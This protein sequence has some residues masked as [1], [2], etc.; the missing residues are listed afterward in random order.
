M[1]RIIRLHD[2]TCRALQD[3]LPWYATGRLDPAEHAR[4]EAHVAG[5]PDCQAELQVER[6]LAAE[7]AQLP[8]GV[9]QGWRRMQARLRAEPAAPPRAKAAA[10]LF[11]WAGWATAAATVI[12]VAGVL[13]LSQGRSGRYHALGAPSAARPGNV[14]V[15]FRPSTREMDL[16]RALK[17]ADARLVD[18]P[19]DADAYVLAVRP[20]RRTAALRQLRAEADVVL[21]EPV[22]PGGG[23]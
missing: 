1:G 3:L 14:V 10:A 23:P 15:I 16:R 8:L 20:E 13:A 7:V 21:A 22:D 9:E 4:V 5:C 6:R 17:A 12:A 11:P 19:T 18:G 2:E